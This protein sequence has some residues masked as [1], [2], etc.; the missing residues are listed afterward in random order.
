MGSTLAAAPDAAGQPS[1]SRLPQSPGRGKSDAPEDKTHIHPPDVLRAQKDILK[2][3][4]P[5]CVACSFQH[6]AGKFVGVVLLTLCWGLLGDPCSLLVH[7]Q[8]PAPARA[9]AHLPQLQLSGPHRPPRLFTDTPRLRTSDALLPALCSPRRIQE[10]KYPR[11]SPAFSAGFGTAAS[12]P[13]PLRLERSAP[14]TLVHTLEPSPSHPRLTPH[15]LHLSHA[16]AAGTVAA[17]LSPH[18]P[19]ILTQA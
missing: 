2:Y 16:H 11:P 12:T 7:L 1:C 14:S 18:F 15:S 17:I 8:P 3:F 5:G 4:H 13:Y 19:A 10:P 9:H 6:R